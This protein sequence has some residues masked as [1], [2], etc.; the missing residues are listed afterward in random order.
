MEGG[1][2]V[3]AR[4]A[5][6]AVAAPPPPLDGAPGLDPVKAP[7]VAKRVVGT[8]YRRATGLLGIWTGTRWYCEH[9]RQKSRCRH[10]GG[11][12]MCPHGRRKYVC[13]DCG[14]SDICRHDKRY[15]LC[16]VRNAAIL[17]C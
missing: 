13:H 6:V 1:G 10:C 2:G 17:L 8:T 7:R 14:G 16:K 5:D 9:G 3:A 4:Q 12:G 11:A 15:S